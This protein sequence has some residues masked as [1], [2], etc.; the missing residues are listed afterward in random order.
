MECGVGLIQLVNV[1]VDI[2]ECNIILIFAVAV[3][4]PDLTLPANGVITYTSTTT[5][6]DVGSTATYSCNP[7]Y[8]M[9]ELTVR[10]CTPSGWS[11]GDDPVCTGESDVLFN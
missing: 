8:L 5:P 10:T 6:R 4:C 2:V 1:S 7:G 3:A 11:T 9:T